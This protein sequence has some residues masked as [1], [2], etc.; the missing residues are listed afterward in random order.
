VNNNINTTYF[1]F[2]R[3]K[4]IITK[5]NKIDSPYWDAKEKYNRNEST[6]QPI[7]ERRQRK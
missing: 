5:K 3:K 1:N 6:L 4:G 7:Q 2:L